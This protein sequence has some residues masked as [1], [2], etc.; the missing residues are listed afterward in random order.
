MKTPPAR[1]GM[2]AT[3]SALCLGS[4]ALMAGEI[5]INPSVCQPYTASAPD[6]E[7]LRM[8]P[9]GFTNLHPTSKFVICPLPKDAEHGWMSPDRAD[10]SVGVH[11]SMPSGWIPRLTSNQCTLQ[12]MS[13]GEWPGGAMPPAVTRKASTQALPTPPLRAA[14]RFTQDDFPPDPVLDG[15]GNA[16][17]ICRIAPN[18]TLTY[19]VLDEEGPAFLP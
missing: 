3:I 12:V 14:I 13:G 10:W 4:Q 6:Y 15:S 7:L 8:Q 5:A 17:L 16:V 18:N 19:I 1:T 9:T 2:L 11:F